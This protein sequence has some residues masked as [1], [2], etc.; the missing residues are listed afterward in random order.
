MKIGFVPFNPSIGDV[1]ANAKKILEFVDQ[2][3]A[4][5]CNVV[6]FPELCLCG[7][8]ASDVFHF[9]FLHETQARVLN[10]LKRK[11]RRISII[12]AGVTRLG[13]S[14]ENGLGNAAYV[15]HNGQREKHV[16]MSLSR[17]GFLAETAYF[18]AGVQPY[19][20]KLGRRKIGVLCTNADWMNGLSDWAQIPAALSA[21]GEKDPDCLILLSAVP[22]ALGK[23][24]SRHR[25]LKKIAQSLACDVIELNLSGAADEA[26][27][28]GGVVA[29]S[30]KGTLVLD[31]ARFCEEL[32]ALDLPLSPPEKSTAFVSPE[33]TEELGLALKTGIR[34]FVTK[35]KAAKVLVELTGGA[36]SA[37]VAGLAVQA[38]GPAR[39]TGVI[40]ATSTAPDEDILIAGKVADKLGIQNHFLDLGGLSRDQEKIL[41]KLAGKN[42]VSAAA[43]SVAES[44]LGDALLKTLAVSEN[45]LFLAAV[46]KTDLAF[47]SHDYP[48]GFKADLNVLA[49]LTDETMRDLARATIPD[50]TF[51]HRA[52]PT[53]HIGRDRLVEAWVEERDI[54]LEVL[55]LKSHEIEPFWQSEALRRK[56]PPGLRITRSGFGTGWKL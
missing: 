1:P 50:L 16:K 33:T 15:F 4:S 5:Q 9:A 53:S 31:S 7:A 52:A 10:E 18:K 13:P 6:V 41:K 14:D 51:W 19:F 23:H 46:T 3:I 21:Y 37:L 43:F 39:V 26:I 17:S 55:E 45:A 12:V 28:D 35:K 56:F 24:E 36:K 29:Y 42:A 44:D 47:A 22:F 8:P 40:V 34:D 20:I 11:S 2:A 49:D 30:K 27:F 32:T 54:S 38:L 48:R 25:F